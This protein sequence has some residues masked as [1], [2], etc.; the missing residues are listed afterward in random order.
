MKKIVSLLLALTTLLGLLTACGGAPAA[1][2]AASTP[3][4]TSA[5]AAASTSEEV[6]STEEAPASA[7]EEVPTEAPSVESIPI[8]MP[9]ANHDITYTM[10]LEWPPFLEGTSYATPNDFPFYQNLSAVSGV[11]FDFTQVSFMAAAEQFNLMVASE[12]YTDII[13]NPDK[14]SGSVDEAIENDIF[15]DVTDLLGDYAPNYLNVINRD[16]ETRRDAYSQDGRVAVFWEIAKTPYPANSGLVIRQDWLDEVGMEKPETYEE[17]HD[18]LLAFKNELGAASPIYVDGNAIMKELTAGYGFQADFTDLDGTAV[19]S[20]AADNFSTYMEMTHQWYEEGLIHQDFYVY[21]ENQVESDSEKVRLINSDQVGVWYNWCEDLQQ[22]ESADPDYALSAITNP[23]RNK[24]DEIHLCSGVDP[25]VS[26]MGGWA[27]S[28]NCAADKVPTAMQLIDYLYTEDGSVMAN[29]GIE[30]D[31][32]TYQEDGTPRYT[33]VVLNNS[34]LFTNAAIGVYCVFRGPILSDLSRFN[35]NVVGK[36]A[37][38]VD[39]WS[40]QDNDHNMPAVSMNADDSNRYNSIKSD[41]DTALDEA[42][43]KFI[44]GDRPMEEL[45]GFLDELETMGLSEMVELEQKALDAYYQK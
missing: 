22:Y 25:M 36:L 42:L 32:F 17:L 33:D 28:T 44:I 9:L 11:D 4:E 6:T 18:V 5:E 14:Y 40:V 1:S 19:F 21:A 20:A 34:E 24:G 37:E 2:S 3:D 41:I 16:D 35:Q 23:V 39:V 12:S 27:I 45:P 30:N 43:P 29:W 15:A 13:C 26:T 31:T 10:W 8:A 38:Y 7:A